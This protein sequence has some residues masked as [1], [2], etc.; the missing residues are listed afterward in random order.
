M[1]MRRREFLTLA[2]R[3][4]PVLGE[5]EARR[6]AADVLATSKADEASVA[7]SAS[8]RSNTRYAVNRITTAGETADLSAA[9]TARFGRREAT[10]TVNELDRESLRDAVRRAEEMA[11]LAP[12]DPESMPLL[13]PQEYEPSA[14]WH[15]STAA[16]DADRR[17]AVAAGAIERAGSAEGDLT[18]A[19]FLDVRR[20]ARALANSAGLF[21]Y[22]PA[23]SASYSLTARTADGTGSGWA[24]VGQR[25]W[26][27]V[28]ADTLH[29]AAIER[30][31]RSRR[32]QPLEPGTYPVILGPQAVA[33]LVTLLVWSLDARAADEGRSAFAAPGGNRLGELVVDERVTLRS[34]PI[35]AGDAPFASDGLPERPVA[36]I[37]NGV[38]RNLV[39]TRFWG[40]AKGRRPTGQPATFRMAGGEGSVAD[41]IARTE[42]AV[43]VTR[44][45]YIRSVDPRTILYTGLTRDGTFWVEDGEISHPVNNF[46]WNDSPLQLLR[47]LEALGRPV[48]VTGAGSDGGSLREVPPLRASRFT[49]SSVSEA[50]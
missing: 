40:R 10:L 34:D 29:A 37:E 14:G 44:L 38:L 32:P 50:V 35:A 5:D 11:R 22:H 48:R 49:F 20:G 45:W 24:G 31:L 16:L 39:Y 43:L 23:T 1:R 17:A 30:A 4:D 12:E 8:L 25:D 3:S 21:A 47:H 19:G 2:G 46:R 6:I 9:V 13:G 26:A 27:A 18:V 7:L 41:L 15:D 28:N 33:D 42:R 36:W